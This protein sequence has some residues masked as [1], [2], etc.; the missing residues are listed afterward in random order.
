VGNRQ[1]TCIPSLLAQ[2]N[3]TLWDQDVLVVRVAPPAASPLLQLANSVRSNLEDAGVVMGPAWAAQLYFYEGAGRPAF[4]G[5][6][7]QKVHVAY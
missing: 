1:A 6:R 4:A 5:P 7:T 3:R 2:D